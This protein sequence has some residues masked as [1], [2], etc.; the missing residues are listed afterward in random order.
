[1]ASENKAANG[2]IGFFGL[3]TL[4][5]ITLKLTGFIHWSWVWVLAPFWGVLVFVALVLSIVLIAVAATHRH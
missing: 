4:I 2:G 1:M 5:F 3:L